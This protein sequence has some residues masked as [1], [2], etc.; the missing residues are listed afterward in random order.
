VEAEKSPRSHWWHSRQANQALVLLAVAALL[1]GLL[2]SQW[3]TVLT[4]ATLL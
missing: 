1:G 4:H 2:L 3:E